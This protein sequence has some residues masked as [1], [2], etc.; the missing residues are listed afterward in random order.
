MFPIFICPSNQ[1][2]TDILF[3]IRLVDDLPVVTV[4]NKSRD[5]RESPGDQIELGY[6]LGQSININ[7]HLKFILFYNKQEK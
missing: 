7:N 4:V 6:R 5:V 2:L 3:A 1:E